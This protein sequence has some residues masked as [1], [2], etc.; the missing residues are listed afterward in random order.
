MKS[1]SG[2]EKLKFDNAAFDDVSLNRK[3]SEFDEDKEKKT[4]SVHFVDDE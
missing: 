3:S 2:Y 1:T 4:K